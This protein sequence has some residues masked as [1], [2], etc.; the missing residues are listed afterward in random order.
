M[1]VNT[2]IALQAVAIVILMALAGCFTPSGSQTDQ[3]DADLWLTGVTISGMDGK[4]WGDDHIRFV[5]NSTAAPGA[6]PT[7]LPKTGIELETGSATPMTIRSTLRWTDPDTVLELHTHNG[8][9]DVACVADGGAP[10]TDGMS[11]VLHEGVLR[12]DTYSLAKQTI[13]IAVI[14]YLVPDEPTP[15]ELQVDVVRTTAPGVDDAMGLRFF[16]PARVG[17]GASAEAS[18]LV[19]PDGTWLACSHG[20]FVIPSPVWVSH[21]AGQT[22]SEVT[23]IEGVGVSGDCDL[24]VTDNGSWHVVYDVLDVALAGVPAL[25]TATVA[26]SS[27]AGT[28][29]EIHNVIGQ[30]ARILDRPWLTPD[31]NDLVLTYMT[32]LQDPSIHSF[33]RSMDHGQSWS[34]HRIMGLSDSA[35]PTKAAGHPILWDDGDEILVPAVAFD[36]R[37]QKPR[38]T[39]QQMHRSHD[40]GVT[41]E[42]LPVAGPYSTGLGLATATRADDGTIYYAFGAG[43]FDNAQILVTWSLDEGA[44]WHVPIDVASGLTMRSVIWPWIDARPDGTAT[45]AWIAQASL[46]RQAGTQAYVARIDAHAASPVQFVGPITQPTHGNGYYEFIM[47]DHD[48]DGHAV[49]ATVTQDDDCQVGNHPAARHQCVYTIKERPIASI[50]L[51]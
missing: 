43:T 36:G 37:A 4:R 40:G 45:I 7:G 14:T 39:W 27:N 21:D 28:S 26:T 47:V 22:W 35:G 50:N 13:E 12:C 23:N 46:D 15:F 11:V 38:D 33:T 2:R 30:Q 31:G 48:T 42:T 10:G 24:A 20:G 25:A 6:E 18:I 32:W 19:A 16:E 5:W 44:T 29:W 49:V 1:D 51:R 9:D 8:A 34:P 41:W 3:A 17:G